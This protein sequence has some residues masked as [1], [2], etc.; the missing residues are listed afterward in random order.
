MCEAGYKL[1]AVKT[2]SS[3][4][5]WCFLFTQSCYNTGGLA[6]S[7]DLV[8]SVKSIDF[9]RTA[10]SFKSLQWMRD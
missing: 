2:C 6:V 9:G 4:V 3:F 8:F 5:F 10:P 1:R 7:T